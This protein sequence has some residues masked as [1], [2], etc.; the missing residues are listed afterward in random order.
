MRPSPDHLALEALGEALT[1]PLAGGRM[2][3]P[4]C[5][6]SL[7]LPTLRLGYRRPPEEELLRCGMVWDGMVWCG[8][9]WYGM[10]WHGMV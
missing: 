5:G 9:V 1:W 10:E 4:C 8:V 6:P 2:V 7:G 3:G